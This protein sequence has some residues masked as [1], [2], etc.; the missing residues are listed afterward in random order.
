MTGAPNWSWHDHG[1]DGGDE[2]VWLDVLDTPL[3]GFLDTVF[4]EN[5]PEPAHP[6]TRPDDD[7]PARF[8]S[9]LAPMGARHADPYSPVFNYSYAQARAALEALRRADEWD[10]CHGI[11][12]AYVNPT[13]GGPPTPTMAA[14]LQ[15]LPKGFDGADYRSTDG[16]VYCV[17][18]GSG[19]TVID[20][21]TLEWGPR[22]VFTVPGWHRHRHTAEPDAVL[23][24]LSDRPVQQALSL[25][26]E[27]RFDGAE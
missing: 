16:T 21:K 17:V 4:R 9:G 13:N 10:A 14:F 7:G 25:W 3:V 27:E 8:G 19:R 24:S 20:G 18:E 22:D 6:L 23:F 1:S 2:V 11:K 12:Q 26:R 5:Y 15:L